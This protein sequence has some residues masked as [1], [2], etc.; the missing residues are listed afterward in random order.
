MFARARLEPGSDN[1]KSYYDMRPE[2]EPVDDLF[3][4]RPGFLSANALYGDSVLFALPHASFELTEAMHAIVDGDPAAEIVALPDNPA[5]TQLVKALARYYGA[6]DAGVTR[7]KPEHIYTH[8]GRGSGVYG[9]PIELPHRF[10]VAF[11][12]EMDHEIMGSAPYAPVVME[13]ARQYVEAGRIAVQLAAAIHGWDTRH[14]PT[15][16]A[17]TASSAR[18]WRTMQGWARSG[19]WVC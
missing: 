15:S 6:L 2:N 1:Y 9:A 5:R 8:I 19:A 12:V 7:L 17:I 16:T 11:T 13:S 10:A 14:T 18:S 4:Q 3:R